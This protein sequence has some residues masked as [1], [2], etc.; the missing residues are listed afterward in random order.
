MKRDIHPKYNKSLKVVC[1][2]GNTFETGST[3]ETDTL[4]VELCSKCHPFY[5]GEQ[6]IVDT[7]NVVKKFEERAQKAAAMSFRSK[8]EKME[9][10]KNKKDTTIKSSSTLTLKD[11]LSNANISK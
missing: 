9:A 2:C 10:R 1:S 3:L 6:K 4:N 7:D 5:T 8:R 11:M